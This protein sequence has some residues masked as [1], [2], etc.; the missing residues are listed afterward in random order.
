[1]QRQGRSV[2]GELEQASHRILGERVRVRGQGRTD[3]GVHALGQVAQCA[4]RSRLSTAAIW[5]A[6]NALL[7]EDIVVHRV[8]GVPRSFHARFDAKARRY[9]YTI[10]NRPERPVL[11]R[12][13]VA[14]VRT[15]L[16]VALMRR[17]ARSL[18]GRHDFSAFQASSRMKRNPVRR[19]RSLRIAKRDEMI[20]IDIIAG[21]FVHHMVRN[22][23]GTLIEIGRGKLPAGSLAKILRSRHRSAAGP[24]AP[25]EGLCLVR[26]DY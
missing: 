21:S 13:Q 15:P 1:M 7:P 23:V 25:P 17:E 2:Q 26:V 8:E 18:V 14:W 5:R 22:I 4:T 3:T 12:H 11:D 24:T 9:R 6:L 19:V 10:L 16:D 20:Y